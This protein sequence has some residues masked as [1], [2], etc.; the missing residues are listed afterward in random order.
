VGEGQDDSSNVLRAKVRGVSHTV[1]VCDDGSTRDFGYRND[2]LRSMDFIRSLGWNRRCLFGPLAT[3][4]SRTY[5]FVVC[6]DSCSFSEMKNV[7][8]KGTVVL[9][10]SPLPAKNSRQLERA[11]IKPNKHAHVF[12]LQY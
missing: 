11:F 8:A 5:E 7:F 4:A 3:D 1:S 2:A 10:N 6:K 9:S 12:P